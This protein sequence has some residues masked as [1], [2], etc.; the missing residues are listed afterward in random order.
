[1]NTEEQYS[2]M[3][4]VFGTLKAPGLTDIKFSPTYRIGLTN[5]LREQW[6]FRMLP[7]KPSDVVADI[8]CAA[9]RQTLLAAERGQRAIGTDIAKSFVDAATAFAQQ[10]GITN[11]SFLMCP[12]EQL[13]IPDAS[14]DALIC[15]EVLEHVL[16]PETALR[17][18]Y[19]ILKPGG[20]ALITVPN[21]NADGT[22]WGRL[23]RMLRLRSFSPLT[24]FTQEAMDAHGD[25]HVRE[26]RVPTLRQFLSTGGF[27]PMEWTTVSM[28]DVHDR[29]ISLLLRVGV[30]RW[31]S[32]RLE[33]GLSTLRLPFGR[34]IIML[35][36][37]PSA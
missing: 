36:R 2:E 21:M 4:E 3:W 28:I 27:V 31:L 29:A 14:V 10:R 7:I 18:L 20:L 8:G 5:Y 11:A 26:F 24:T 19:R 35:C 25:C 23:M 32:I 1:M 17:E 9:G 12:I 15:S 22:L 37:K 33:N 30:I 34:H 16:N 6:I 13:Q